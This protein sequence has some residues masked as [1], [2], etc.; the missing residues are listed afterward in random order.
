MME[1]PM[2]GGP[3]VTSWGILFAAWLGLGLVLGMLGIITAAVVAR[4]KRR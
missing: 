3:G 2:P 4:R 1:P